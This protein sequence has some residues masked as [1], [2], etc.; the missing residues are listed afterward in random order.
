M[1]RTPLRRLTALALLVLATALAGCLDDPYNDR[2]PATATTPARSAQDEPGTPPALPD[3]PA[4]S[5]R[6][7]LRRFALLYTNWRFESL[8]RTRAA[9]ARQATGALRAQ[10][11]R[12]ARD[13]A[14][15]ASQRASTQRNSGVVAGILIEP[16]RPAYA[17]VR[18]TAWYGDDPRES[19]WFLYRA[20]AVETTGGWLV[21]RW[22][23]L[24]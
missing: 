11:E 15:D 12:D 17:I 1:P 5:A 3:T 20:Q 4:P 18:E 8:A 19:S 21:A 10:L 22:Q 16:G 7:A 24:N 13:A 14:D 6:E 23:A 9:L 2:R